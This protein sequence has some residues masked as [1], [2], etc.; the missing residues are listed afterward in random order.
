[1]MSFLEA[2]FQALR[3]AFSRNATFV[4]F[5][6]LFVC[7]VLRT[8]LYGVSSVASYSPNEGTKQ[9]RKN[10]PTPWGITPSSPKMHG[11]RHK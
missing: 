4:W 2:Q 8:D 1:M 10:F 6:V 11:A 7:V 3:P 9:I 5:V